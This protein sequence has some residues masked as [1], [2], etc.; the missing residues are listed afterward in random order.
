MKL[1]QQEV[2][3]VRHQ[4]ALCSLPGTLSYHPDRALRARCSL[5]TTSV[6]HTWHCPTH[7]RS[8]HPGIPAPSTVSRGQTGPL[9]ADSI[10]RMLLSAMDWWYCCERGLVILGVSSRERMSLAT[11]LSPCLPFALPFHC[12]RRKQGDSQQTL[13]R[14]WHWR[15]PRTRTVSQK[16]S[17]VYD[18]P[19]SGILLKRH[20]TD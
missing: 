4:A 18:Y 13:S 7:L 5:P 6:W 9:G 11:F 20:K 14:C 12:E 3:G 1:W 19:V 8:S 15:L 17:T 16:P 2:L 10:A